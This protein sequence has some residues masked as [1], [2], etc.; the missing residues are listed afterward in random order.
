MY[1]EAIAKPD[2]EHGVDPLH[3]GTRAH[4]RYHMQHITG[5][6][7]HHRVCMLRPWWGVQST[8]VVPGGR[9]PHDPISK[10]RAEPTAGEHLPDAS[11][12]APTTPC[13]W[14]SQ[15]DMSPSGSS[16]DGGEIREGVPAA[17][18]RCVAL[19]HRGRGQSG[20]RGDTNPSNS[21]GQ[22]GCA[23]GVCKRHS[24]L[25][26]GFGL[27]LGWVWGGAGYPGWVVR[28]GSKRRW[29]RNARSGLYARTLL[30]VASAVADRYRPQLCPRTQSQGWS[31]WLSGLVVIPS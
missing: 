13:G 24:R 17:G 9:R 20:K 23:I 30:A 15:S 27:G 5:D 21:K 18:W 19:A 22:A 31:G 26:L 25:G 12:A 29:R 11:N 1:V 8:C 14:P 10:H 6:L 7:V 28:R 4:C 16:L 2:G 3:E